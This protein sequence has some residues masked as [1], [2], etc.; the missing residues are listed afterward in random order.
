MGRIYKSLKDHDGAMAHF[1]KAVELEPRF[2]P[3]YT[4]LGIL[5]LEQGEND[6]ALEHFLKALAHEVNSQQERNYAGLVLLRQNKFEDAISQ[7]QNSLKANPD[8]QLYI[9][10][11]LGAA[12][13]RKGEME[14]SLKCLKKVLSINHRHVPAHLHLIE[15]YLLKGEAAKA[16]QTAE[17]LIGLFPDDKLYLLVDKMII[18]GDIL[19][20]PPNMKIVSPTLEK[21]M[22]KKGNDYHELARKLENYSKQKSVP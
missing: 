12:Y 20:E 15:S 10:T 18:H 1:L 6:K 7:F 14:N 8:D 16:D 19:I 17:E 5:K 11:H 3:A 22:I 13:K 21:A 2:P 4:Y 9:L